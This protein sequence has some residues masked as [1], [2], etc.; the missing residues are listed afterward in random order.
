[1]NGSFSGPSL[2]ARIEGA[3]LLA[4]IALLCVLAV[5]QHRWLGA[6]ALA[7]RQKLVEE[8]AEKAAAIAQEVDRELTRVFLEL[9]I[10]AKALPGRVGSAARGGA[11]P[12][13][14]AFAE[15]FERWRSESA[16][17]GL[18][19]AVYVAERSPAGPSALLRFD[20]P[21]RTFVEEPWPD[22]LSSVR[23]I[24]EERREGA[25]RAVGVSGLSAVPFPILASLPP[26]MADV[27]AL[28][29]PVVDV[30]VSERRS[31]PNV[32]AKL[33]QIREMFMRHSGPGPVEILWLDSAYLREK[34]VAALARARLGAD[35]PFNWSVVKTTDGA[36]IAGTPS[37][38]GAEAD[39]KAP[40]LRLRIDD[41]DRSLLRGVLPGLSET[42]AESSVRFVVQLGRPGVPGP[43]GG[44]S[45][46]A[47]PWTLQLRHREG[48]IDAAVSSQQRRNTALSASILG[49]LG[50]SAG[51]VFFS[52]RKLRAIATRQVEFVASVSH[53]L[54]TPLSVI[55]S[56][57]DNLAAGV[58]QDKDQTKRYGALIRDESVRLADMVEHVLE[59]A[60]ADSPGRSERGPVD[61][62]EAV[63]A[64]VKGMESLTADRAGRVTIDVPSDSL[65]VNGDLSNLTRAVSNLLGNA[66]KYG[67]DPPRVTVRARAVPGAIE[68][69][70]S[71]EG[72]GLSP[73]EVPRL[74][75]PFYRGQRASEAHI[76][77]SGLGLAL[78]KRIVEGHGGRVTAASGAS[79][80]AAFT[81]VLPAIN[82]TI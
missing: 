65:R 6:I 18:V 28:L 43:P 34:V 77:G 4:V 66:L 55:R 35:G 61:A 12:A 21:T 37:G 80:G 69:A 3:A 9:R 32:S 38:A 50:L 62:V 60:G 58:V 15:Q 46:P 27:P 59:F 67:G 23:S 17:A 68:I 45:G 82:D 79:G 19:R 20:P 24:I 14:P 57:A 54:R 13:G 74:F 70:V 2:R 49:V 22:E 78:V 48:S 47:G 36:A 56:A 25:I 11:K 39:A 33:T 8:S 7:E 52:A 75:E 71:D 72:P 44:T 42:V 26:V 63:R 1:M 10:D 53:E 64:A 29:S 40:M 81:I 5:V 16:H 30:V 51:L 76:P 31:D 73:L 41:L